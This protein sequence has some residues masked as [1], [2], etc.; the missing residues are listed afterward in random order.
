MRYTEG[1]TT[2]LFIGGLVIIGVWLSI[3]L[4]EILAPGPTLRWRRRILNRRGDRFGGA[5]VAAAFDGMTHEPDDPDG[6]RRPDVQQR[7]RIIGFVNLALA[8]LFG[9]FLVLAAR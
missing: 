3:A 4:L 6:W 5:P 8:V 2:P 7:V 1:T 9:V